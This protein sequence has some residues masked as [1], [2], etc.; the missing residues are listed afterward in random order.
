MSNA[1][2][3]LRLQA[4]YAVTVA[5]SLVRFGKLLRLE[6]EARRMNGRK[7]SRETF[8]HL[9][10]A[11]KATVQS[12]EEG[13][14]MPQLD[15]GIQ[16]IL[17]LGMSLDVFF[18]RVLDATDPLTKTENDGQELSQATVI[19]SSPLQPRQL[20]VTTP[21]DS[22]T[23][24]RGDNSIPSAQTPWQRDIADILSVSPTYADLVERLTGQRPRR[25]RAKV[26]RAKG[27]KSRRRKRGT[28]DR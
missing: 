28:S 15:Y 21:H 23:A 18:S 1:V 5:F 3:A 16:A 20:G 24:G 8:G 7:V 27:A 25:S 22:S 4:S 26:S 2:Y 6:R 9:A 12:W 19:K 11:N 14:K 13:A 17:T 10:G